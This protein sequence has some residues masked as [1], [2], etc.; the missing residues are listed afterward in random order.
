MSDVQLTTN[1]SGRTGQRNGIALG[2]GQIRRIF[3]LFVLAMWVVAGVWVAQG[4]WSAAATVLAVEALVVCLVVFVN[5]VWVFNLGY[6]VCALL[7]NLTVLLAVGRPTAALVV[8]GV[9]VLYGLRLLLFSLGRLRHP[10]FV[11][12]RAGAA[13]AHTSLP[14]AVKVIV[15]LQ[16]ATLFTFQ[17][18][19]TYALARGDVALTP[20]VATGA[21]VM[22]L[23]LVVEAVA[24]RQKQR[25]KMER[26]QSW[27]STGVYRRTRHPNYA[28]EI[29]VQVGLVVCAVGAALATGEWGWAFVGLVLSPTYIVLLM[30][31]ATTGAE[32]AKQARYG[33]DPA[34]R[35]YAA[36]S[37]ALLPRRA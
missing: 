37:G 4:R 27:V 1:H 8:G 33:A 36:R 12:R 30:L 29:L 14:V 13:A 17:A 18:M 11:D 20:V 19:T 16:T 2:E 9:L 35:A 7:L 3:P 26:P 5:F 24:D 10:A 31:S 32:L 23:G 25:A 22:M 15:W 21:A 6:A 28:A 34:Y